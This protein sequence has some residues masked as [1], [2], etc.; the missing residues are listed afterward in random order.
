MIVLQQLQL[1]DNVLRRAVLE[2]L[3][4][5]DGRVRHA[6]AVALVRYVVKMGS[7]YCVIVSVLYTILYDLAHC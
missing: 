4:D 7:V 3:G 2:L 5:E 6:S 1:Q